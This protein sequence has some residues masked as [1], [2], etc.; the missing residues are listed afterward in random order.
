MI[1]TKTQ[2]GQVNSESVFILIV[3]KIFCLVVFLFCSMVIGSTEFL[4]FIF[5]FLM[6]LSKSIG[7]ILLILF[8]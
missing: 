6:I 4:L 2:I 7:T 8:R 1:K 3:D 5:V